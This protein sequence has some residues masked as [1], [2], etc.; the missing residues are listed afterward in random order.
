MSE[1]FLGRNRV[2]AFSRWL[3]PAAV[4]SPR[5]RGSAHDARGACGHRAPAT[6]GGGLPVAPVG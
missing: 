2:K 4:A 3:G 1:Q 6:R 5:H